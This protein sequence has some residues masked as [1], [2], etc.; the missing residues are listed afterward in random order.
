M[1][2]TVEKL[3]ATL[4]S[5]EKQVLA[6]RFGLGGS[7]ELTLLEVGERLQLSKERVRQIQH[8]A[9]KRLRS[10]ATYDEGVAKLTAALERSETDS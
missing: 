7:R 9:L 6:L 8:K 5:R 2:E 4:T 1:D 10:L 3:L